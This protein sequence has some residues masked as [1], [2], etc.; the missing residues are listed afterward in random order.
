MGVDGEDGFGFSSLL[1]GI[2][3]KWRGTTIQFPPG[4][5]LVLN[6]EGADIGGDVF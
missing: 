1:K 6:N 4:S 2:P 3:A 5:F